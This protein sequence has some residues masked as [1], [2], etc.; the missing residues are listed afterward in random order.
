MEYNKIS[1]VF[2][3]IF[4]LWCIDFL[5]T[6]FLLRMGGRFYETNPIQAWFYSFGVIGFMG[7]FIFNM[8]FILGLTSIA[9]YLIEKKTSF[10]KSFKLFLWFMFTGI[11]VGWEIY[12][13][14]NNVSLILGFGI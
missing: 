11:F 12:A 9:N 4:G 13:I 10:E 2:T 5:T 7:S 8:L 6:I 1:K 14:I 3:I